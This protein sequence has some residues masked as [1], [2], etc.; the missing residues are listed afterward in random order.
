MPY[1]DAIPKLL[2]VGELLYAVMAMCVATIFAL[3]HVKILEP[4]LGKIFGSFSSFL[5]IVGSYMSIH[6]LIQ[7]IFGGVKEYVTQIVIENLYGWST[8]AITGLTIAAIFKWLKLSLV[9]MTSVSVVVAACSVFISNHIKVNELSS[10]S[11]KIMIQWIAWNIG[12]GA[13]FCYLI[14]VIQELQEPGEKECRS[15]NIYQDLKQP[16]YRAITTFFAQVFLI[17]IYSAAIIQD[18]EAFENEN[19][20]TGQDEKQYATID[21][22]FYGIAVLAVSA[23]VFK[24]NPFKYVFKGTIFWSQVMKQEFSYNVS[25]SIFSKIKICFRIFADIYVNVTMLSYILVVL[26]YTTSHSTEPM[27][28]VLNLVAIFSIIDIDDLSP[29]VLDRRSAD[30]RF[31]LL[32]QAVL[33]LQCEVMESRDVRRRHEEKQSKVESFDDG[34]SAISFATENLSVEDDYDGRRGNNMNI[35]YN[36]SRRSRHYENV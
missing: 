3:F 22:A 21:W 23:Y 29:E 5:L 10:L 36:Q 26:P 24:H 14:L 34:I 28:F 27:E 32:E 19:N 12:Y 2:Y 11:D 15:I 13:M 17:N 20:Q 9:E 6:L 18:I 4:K 30:A 31:K 8:V 16:F 1:H 35:E 33:D 25:S 7:E